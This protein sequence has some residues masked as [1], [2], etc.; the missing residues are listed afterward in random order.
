MVGRIAFV[1]GE[2]GAEVGGG[3]VKKASAD[4]HRWLARLASL[5]GA[6][7]S[8]QCVFAGSGASVFLAYALLHMIS[9]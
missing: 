9:C 2:G 4:N 8:T 3:F 5:T 7:T 1:G 6:S